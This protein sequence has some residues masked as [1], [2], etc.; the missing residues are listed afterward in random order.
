MPESP[1]PYARALYAALRALDASGASR[2][3]AEAVPGG[4]D[5]AAVADRLERAAAGG[6]AGL[7]GP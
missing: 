3:L 7:S 6:E 2:I 1:R 4:E 5:W